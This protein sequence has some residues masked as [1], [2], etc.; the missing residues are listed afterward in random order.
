[1]K[2]WRNYNWTSMRHKAKLFRIA[3]FLRTT[4]S[5]MEI[6]IEAF[7]VVFTFIVMS[8][9][10]ILQTAGLYRRLSFPKY[11]Y[12]TYCPQAWTFVLISVQA[13]ADGIWPYCACSWEYPL[14]WGTIYICK[15]G[16][17][18]LS[19]GH[20]REEKIDMWTRFFQSY[21]ARGRGEQTRTVN[22]ILSLWQT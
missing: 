17:N 1:M 18:G 22:Y 8:I 19:G 15:H 11:P 12:Q 6:E 16:T 21:H 7:R 14:H 5:C 10:K 9:N 3:W 13:C 2:L 20:E 4:W